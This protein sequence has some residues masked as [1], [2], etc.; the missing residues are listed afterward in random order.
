MQTSKLDG[1]RSTAW[2]CHMA[3]AKTRWRKMCKYCDLHVWKPGPLTFLGT[4]T[5][6][7]AWHW[8][9]EIKNV[10]HG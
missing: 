3:P 5:G 9:K 8:I 6:L 1:G 7:C 4:R 10:P 2:R